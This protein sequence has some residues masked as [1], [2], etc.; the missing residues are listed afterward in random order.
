MAQRAC[1]IDQESRAKHAFARSAHG[2]VLIGVVPFDAFDV[3]AQFHLVPQAEVFH[4][5]MC[6]A[7]QFCLP[8][9]HLRPEKRRKGQRIQGG[10]D[11]DGCTGIGV[12][13]PGAAEEIPPFQQSKIIDAGFEQIDRGALPAKSAADDQHLKGLH[14]PPP[15]VID[16]PF[17]HV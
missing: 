8:G 2:P 13:A 3:G 1:G 14:A 6:V 17:L 15:I 10:G 12:L 4:Y 11:V 9:E 7:V 16:Q 5:M